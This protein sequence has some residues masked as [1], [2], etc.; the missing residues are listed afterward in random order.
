MRTL[1][2]RAS[3]IIFLF[4]V[5]SLFAS[6]C[7]AQAI[8]LSDKEAII[9]KHFHF[10][11]PKTGKEYPVD[12][13]R[14]YGVLSKKFGADPTSTYFNKGYT[15]AKLMDIRKNYDNRSYYKT[16]VEMYE[17][18]DDAIGISFDGPFAVLEALIKITFDNDPTIA[19]ILLAW[20]SYSI[21][22][23]EWPLINSIVEGYYG[24]QINSVVKEY[25]QDMSAGGDPD[26][27]TEQWNDVRLLIN[28]PNLEAKIGNGFDLHSFCKAIYKQQNAINSGLDQSISDFTNN[29]NNLLAGGSIT[30]P[31]VRFVFSPNSTDLYAPTP[32]TIDASNSAGKGGSAI[33]SY[34]WTVDNIPAGTGSS[35]SSIYWQ[36]GIHTVS[37]TITDA[38]SYTQTG[39]QQFSVG[40]PPIDITAGNSALERD[41]STPANSRVVYYTWDFGDNSTPT[42]GAA[43]TTTSHVYTQFGSYSIRLTEKL[44]DGSTISSQF[45]LN[46]QNSPTDISAGTLNGSQTWTTDGSPYRLHGILTI[47]VGMRLTLSPGVVIQFDSATGIDVYGELVSKGQFSSNNRVYMT[48][49]RDN[50]APLLAGQ[51]QG[52][53][54]DWRGLQFFSGSIADLPATTIR[55]SSTAISGV[56]SN[57]GGVTFDRNGTAVSS[58]DTAKIILANNTLTDDNIGFTIGGNRDIILT[59]NSFSGPNLLNSAFTVSGPI[60]QLQ[61]SGN[62]GVGGSA[63]FNLDSVSLTKSNAWSL[64]NTIKV[65]TTGLTV[66]A[67]AT[68]TLNAGMV[69]QSPGNSA[70]TVNGDLRSSGT[71]TNPAI[72]TGDSDNSPYGGTDNGGLSDWSGVAY[73]KKLK[74]YLKGITIR[75]AFTGVG[76]SPSSVS[77][78]TFYSCYQGVSLNNSSALSSFT[79]TSSTFS[80]CI[81][82]FSDGATCPLTLANNTLT[83]DNIG[84]TISGNRDIILTNNSFSGPNLLNSAF[85]VTGPIGQLQMSGNK[86]VGGSAT[87]NLDSVSLTKSNAWSLQDTVK[88]LSQGLTVNAGAT[89]TLNAG[90][91]LQSPGNSAITVNGDLRSS[92]TATN[93]AILTSWKDDSPYG[94][95]DNGIWNDWNGVVY[96]TGLTANLQGL[97]IRHAFTGVGGSPSSVSNATF[98]SCYQG[99][100]LNNSSALSSFTLT[101][102][103]F[104]TCTRAFSDGATCPLTLTNNTLTDDNIGFT[105]S[106]NRDI[107]LT[108]NSFSGANTLVNAFTVTGPIGQLQMSGNKGAGG[109]AWFH[110]SSLTLSKNNTW[111]LQDT[112]K[113]LSQGLTV[114]AGVT[115]TLNAG[116]VLQNENAITVNGDLRSSGTAANPAILTSWK[117]DSPYGGTDNG[118]LQ[119]WT[120][121]VYASGLTANLQSLVIRHAAAGVGG[122]P[123]SVSN[124]TI[125]NCLYGI[126][127]DPSVTMSSFTLVSNTFSTCMYA[128]NDGGTCALTLTN[129]TVMDGSY[130]FSIS[131]NRDIVLTNNS[132]SG[133]ARS[134]AFTENGP[135]GQLQMSGNKG[136]GGSAT[137]SLTSLTLSKSNTWSLQNTVK[138][139]TT[140]LTIN[141]GTTLTLSPSM[142]L[143]VSGSIT[144]NGDL[145]SSGTASNPAILTSWNDDSPYGGTDYGGLNDWTGV[146][147]ATGLTANLQGLTIRH[148]STALTVDTATLDGCSFLSNSNGIVC[149]NGGGVYRNCN[150]ISNGFAVRNNSTTDIDARGNWWGD[151]TGPYNA[152]NNPTGL[153]NPVSDHVLIG[154]AP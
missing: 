27:D 14:L 75:H 61:M 35:I 76:G 39:S 147:Y 129:N 86:G 146:V 82:A 47:P 92:G 44:S 117:D 84:F 10:K 13:P 71:A 53:I 8:S 134:S 57:V 83:D 99:V 21:L 103:T 121:V 79:L 26:H 5:L 73:S 52:N 74:A 6:K 100:S 55:Y 89:L 9:Q 81:R 109:S 120:G 126:S 88:V 107:V 106:G 60:G 15:T 67:G 96:A 144:V 149:A 141:A 101:S 11:D 56:P 45:P 46:F 64:Q 80:T 20:D 132:F 105:I 58:S 136:V 152:T 54:R 151:T 143:Q 133:S 90:M 108:N 115:L 125:Y 91:V 85:T 128:F 12:S 113:V 142:V 94:G 41:F 95:T 30:Q 48:S 40:S 70:I 138:V 7:Q 112:V 51:D 145:R 123:S 17:L 153:G 31:S 49:Y 139:H 1:P 150:F 68:L 36:P 116:M 135:M 140:G 72:L 104:S 25:L 122:S 124:A 114:N 2:L 24:S 137:F 32:V 78:A 93:P 18:V 98:Y 22:K 50:S 42:E 28:V 87:F 118:G 154:P 148:A 97:I 59:N 119:D 34:A 127:L 131:G 111:S 19:L 33:T 66:N 65:R 4:C 37:V 130:G 69:L 38:S 29:I 63:T 3:V 23:S 43:L 77:N 62:K 16:S 102:S 110:V